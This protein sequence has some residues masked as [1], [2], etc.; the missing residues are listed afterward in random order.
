MREIK[1]NDLSYD[2]R[3]RLTGHRYQ[4]SGSVWEIPYQEYNITYL[5]RKESEGYILVFNSD[6]DY[7]RFVM[8]WL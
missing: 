6:E 8:D 1:W 5:Y 3:V 2:T 4:T 7:V